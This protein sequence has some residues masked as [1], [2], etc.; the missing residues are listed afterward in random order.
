MSE[1]KAS[2]WFETGLMNPSQTAWDGAEWI[3]GSNKDLVFYSHYQLIFK[4]KYSLDIEKESNSASV[5]Y[6]AN[7][8]RLMDKYKNIHQLGNK[9]NENYVNLK[10]GISGVGTNGRG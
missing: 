7:D 8:I 9:R 10:L 1:Y 6:G 4:M 2:S 5:I 3:G